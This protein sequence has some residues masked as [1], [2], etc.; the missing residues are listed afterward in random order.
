MSGDMALIGRWTALDRLHHE[1]EARVGRRLRRQLQLQASEFYALRAVAEAHRAAGRRTPVT[2]LAAAIGL[3]QSATSRLVV[4]L[5]DRGLVTTQIPPHDRRS[6]EVGLAPAAHDVLD[7]GTPVLHHA[8][9]EAVRDAG[10]RNAGDIDGSLL[11][12]LRESCDPAA[13]PSADKDLSQRNP[14]PGPLR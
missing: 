5:R 4:R 10:A 9:C 8:V 14:L 11:R 7:R 12:Y 1:I 2:D 3:S 13:G 6:V